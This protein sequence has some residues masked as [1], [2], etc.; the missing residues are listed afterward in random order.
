MHMCEYAYPTCHSH[1]WNIWHRSA[2][3][4]TRGNLMGTVQDGT[5]FGQ[6]LTCWR[7]SV[8]K[9]LSPPISIHSRRSWPRDSSSAIL[10]TRLAPF[11]APSCVSRRKPGISANL[12]TVC[13]RLKQPEILSDRHS[14]QKNDTTLTTTDMSGTVWCDTDLHVFLRVGSD[15]VEMGRFACVVSD[16]DKNI[17]SL[18]RSSCMYRQSQSVTSITSRERMRGGG[19]EEGIDHLGL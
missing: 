10:R 17:R 4:R 9:L 16:V 18:K 3:M 11:S 14:C 19:R 6:P 15:C 13:K 2:R 12:R 7:N 1:A 5:N 8:C